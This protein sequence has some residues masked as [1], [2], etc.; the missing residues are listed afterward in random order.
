MRTAALLS[1]IVLALAAALAAQMATVVPQIPY[2]QFTLPNGLRVILSEDHAVPVVTESLL[3]NAGGRDE[4]PGS[5]GFAHLFEHLMFEGSAHAPKGVFDQKVEGFGGTDNASTHTDYTFYFETAPSNALPILMWLD[6]DRMAYLNVT[7]EN[8]KNQIA[9]VEEEKRLRVDNQPYGPLLYVALG[10]HAFSNWQNA[11]PVIGSFADLDRATLAEVKAFF[12]AYYAPRN[13]I[14]TIAGDLDLDRTE[15]LVRQYFGWI[16]NRGAIT[17]VSTAE[18]PRTRETDVTLRD[19]H[20]NLPALAIAWQ[21]P[22]RKSPDFYALAL[23][24][25]DLFAGESSRLYQSLVKTRQVAIEVDGGLGF[26]EADFTDYRAP[27][28]FGGFVIYKPNVDPQLV[29]QLVFREIHEIVANGMPQD[30]LLRVKTKL[31]SDWIRGEQTT[32]DRAQLLALGELLDGSPAGE[33]EDLRQI[34]NV[35]SEQIQRAAAAYLTHP[36]VTVLQDEPGAA[37][38]PAAPAKGG[39]RP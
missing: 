19:P 21:G 38:A 25:Q 26:P 4:H 29:E 17:P 36:R 24:G 3:F 35:T 22:P 18:P 37:P 34:L 11:H 10:E 16:P 14:L 27:G 28:L 12:D 5:S 31:A 8:M 30:E 13:A 7:P 15:A 33:S 1:T 32:L 39:A 23:L 9:V 2:R 20:A 6:A